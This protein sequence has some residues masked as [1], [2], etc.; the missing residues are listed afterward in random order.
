MRRFLSGG[1][2][3]GEHGKDP[4]P[5][6]DNAEEKDDGFPTPNDCLMIFGGSAAYDSKHRQKV[7]R[8]KVYMAELATPPFLRWS[9][10]AITFDRTDHPDSVRHLRRYPLVVDLII[11]PKWLTKVLM[12]GGSGLNIMYTET[13][14]AMGVDRVC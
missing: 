9:E 8:C 4:T 10:S 7:A 6:A 2:N 1:S 12:D 11:G 5:T 14:D 13:L 3:K